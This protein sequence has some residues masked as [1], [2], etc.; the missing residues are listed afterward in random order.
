MQ[1][2]AA[3]EHLHSHGIV[4]RDLKPE[5][6]LLNERNH[7]VVIDFGTAKDLVQPGLNGPE[8]VG[9]P[10]F[11]SPE[12]LTGFSGMPKANAM[13]DLWA[14]GAVLSLLHTGSTPFRSPSP[15]LAFLKIKRGLLTRP[16][17]IADDDT[18]DL[19]SQLLQ[20]D[21]S[22][23]LGSD[24]YKVENTKV[25]SNK[26]YDVIRNHPYFNSIRNHSAEGQY[27]DQRHHVIPSLQDLCLFAVSEMAQRDVLDLDLC[28]Q[29]PPGDGSARD[30]TRLS[31]SQRRHILHILDKA[32]V[33]KDGDETRVLQRFFATP[34]EFL[35]SKVRP[36]S[37]NFCGLTQMTDD[38]YRPQSQ[39]GS[40]DPYAK[41][42]KPEAT[43]M[44]VLSN[45]LLVLRRNVPPLSEEEEKKAFTGLKAC[46][47]AINK[48]RPKVVIV[49]AQQTLLPKVWKL[50]ARIRD[51]IPVL[52]TDGSVHYTFW[53]NGFQG[54]LL[55]H[56]ELQDPN[57]TQNLWLREQ[58]EQSRMA[59]PQLFC[60]C[61]CDPR[62][63]PPMVLKQLA[64]GR[65]LCLMGLVGPTSSGDAD[66]ML[67]YPLPYEPNETLD[68]GASVKSTDSVEDEDDAYTMRVLATSLN[69]MGWLT[70]EE[71]E[72]WTTSFEPIPLPE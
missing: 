25:V 67:D 55:Q 66:V 63:L 21:P 46:I 9:T 64:R 6:I 52:W 4:H 27:N 57:S 31:E 41:K 54:L 22:S 44:V 32:K 48:Q 59:K 38:E 16:W 33:F 23:R 5:N 29:H 69:G 53:L 42:D 7:V 40:A 58:M 24:C 18:F 8:F 47:A 72:Q 1:L 13:A 60:F 17:G 36:Q 26:G 15:Y 11:M 28:D 2:I 43:Q 20:V 62:D 56:S 39:R 68:D 19:I 65:V 14:L 61:D 3:L 70:V 49:P 71:S 10:D 12:A 50:L 37:R 34:V 45:P 30:L 51:S 35:K